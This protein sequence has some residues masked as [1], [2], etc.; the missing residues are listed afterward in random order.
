MIL[1]IIESFYIAGVAISE[2]YFSASNFF[3][4]CQETSLKIQTKY[5]ILIIKIN[6]LVALKYTS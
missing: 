3:T 5:K 1:P 6:K 4:R 2:N